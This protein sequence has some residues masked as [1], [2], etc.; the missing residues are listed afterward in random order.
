MFGVLAIFGDLGCSIG[1]M[2]TGFI[3]DFAQKLP[4]I[5]EFSEK[6]FFTAEQLSLKA[7][8]FSGI[9]FPVIMIVGLIMLKEKKER[10]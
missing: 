6:G 2:L 7:G 10:N 4:A 3:S 1:P 5:A 9:I 8:I